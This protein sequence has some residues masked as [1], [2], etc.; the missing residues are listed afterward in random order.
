MGFVLA[1]IVTLVVL[2][3]GGG[4]GYLI[5]V[6]TAPKKEI[7]KAKVYQLSD[8]VKDISIGKNG[9]IKGK[10]KLKD[11]IPY[12]KDIL[13]K[14][15]KE[16]GVTIFR[17]KKLNKPTP[18]V[19]AGC[20]EMWTDGKEVSVLYHDGTCTLLKQGYDVDQGNKIF[21]PL[22]HH[23]INNIKSEMAIR[24]DR[25]RKEKDILQA[26]TPWIVAGIAIIG[27][28]FISYIVVEGLVKVSD[29]TVKIQEMI[30]QRTYGTALP[31]QGQQVTPLDKNKDDLGAEKKE[32]P[33]LEEY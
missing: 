20:S 22:P 30:D 28:I 16:P 27:L 12:T 24:K 7:W 17:L 25:I 4:L 3:I 33:T 8:G 11:L 21:N 6:K 13:E 1:F 23:R 18:A 29:N 14:V 15:D 2:I 10:L 32:V 26:V 19:E 5:Y 9:E 31:N